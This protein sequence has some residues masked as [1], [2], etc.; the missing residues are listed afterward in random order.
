MSDD[1]EL[2][3]FKKTKTDHSQTSQPLHLAAVLPFKVSNAPDDSTM[4][5]S[6]LRTLAS[7]VYASRNGTERCI[8]VHYVG[9]CVWCVLLKIG[10]RVYDLLMKGRNS[11]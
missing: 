5:L 7:T 2:L 1:R 6:L 3:S 10:L 4:D 8:A 11:E 9:V